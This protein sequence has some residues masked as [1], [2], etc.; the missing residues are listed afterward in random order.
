MRSLSDERLVASCSDVPAAIREISE[1][2]I[3]AA[4]RSC[5]LV[6]SELNELVVHVATRKDSAGVR[7]SGKLS[8][9]LNDL[10]RRGGMGEPMPF[11]PC[12]AALRH[13][14]RNAGYLA[15]KAR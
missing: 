12:A 14:T 7:V 9:D 4:R 2:L 3:D 11:I 6:D 10:P 1:G 15:R 13:A 5:G 8:W